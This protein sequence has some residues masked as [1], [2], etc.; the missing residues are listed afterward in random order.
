MSRSVL[1]C[2]GVFASVVLAQSPGTFTATGN[3]TFARPFPAAVVL[4][5]GKTLVIGYPNADPSTA[6]HSGAELYDLTTGTF[7]I[8]GN[9]PSLGGSSA[10]LLPD[11][12]VLVAGGFICCGSSLSTAELYHPAH[13]APSPVLYSLP[14][15]SQGAILHAATQEIVS[16]ANPAVQ[17]EAL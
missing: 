16:P 5:S 9:A 12:S 13:P 17:G 10:T 2:I 11:G 1:L 14:G 6:S 3:L 7:R 15:G 8:T 4:T